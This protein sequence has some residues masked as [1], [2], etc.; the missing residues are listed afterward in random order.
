MINSDR[1]VYS[2]R[3]PE[4][5]DRADKYEKNG[6]NGIEEAF[7]GRFSKIKSIL[8]YTL[9][10]LAIFTYSIRYGQFR[11]PYS[12]S[13]LRTFLATI[14]DAL[15]ATISGNKFSVHSGYLETTL[16]RSREGNELDIIHLVK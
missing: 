12:I 9:T 15:I 4:V 6:G 8:V 2:N 13:F 14:K 10:N 3:L 16:Q 7:C 11:V 5:Y 1:F